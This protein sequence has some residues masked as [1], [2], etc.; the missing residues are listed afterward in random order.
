M[1][2][3]VRVR[4]ACICACVTEVCVHVCSLQFCHRVD[5]DQGVA[6]VE[7]VQACGR[8]GVRE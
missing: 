1:G 8:E 4:Y 5:Q 7:V 3:G 2:E 6:V